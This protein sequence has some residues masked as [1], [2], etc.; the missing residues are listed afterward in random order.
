MTD[1]ASDAFKI[2]KGTTQGDPLSSL[3][4]NTVLQAA[5]ENDL[6]IRREK[7]MH[8]HQFG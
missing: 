8:G 1:T 4:F 2:E 3:L 6:N 7:G 5:L